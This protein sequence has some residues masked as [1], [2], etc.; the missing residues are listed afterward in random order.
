MIGKTYFVNKVFMRRVGA[1]IVVVVEHGCL[2]YGLGAVFE[3]ALGGGLY[4]YCC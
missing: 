1:K 4:G 3:F 2:G